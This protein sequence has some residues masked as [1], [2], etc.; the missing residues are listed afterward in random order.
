M[1]ADEEGTREACVYAVRE[2]PLVT[3]VDK[4]A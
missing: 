3:E 4:C 1:D 2:T